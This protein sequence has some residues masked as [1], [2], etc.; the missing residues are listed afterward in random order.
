MVDSLADPFLHDGTELAIGASAGVAIFPDD[1]VTA[2][3]LLA[4]ADT[5]MYGAKRD[6]RNRYRF[7]PHLADELSLDLEQRQRQPAPAPE[8]P[9]AAPPARRAWCR[10]A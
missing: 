8:R 2:E 7:C 5:A 6:G 3:E 1:G 10:A 9:G 4:R